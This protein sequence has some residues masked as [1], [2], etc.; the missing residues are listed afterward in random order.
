MRRLDLTFDPQAKSNAVEKI[1]NPSLRF[2]AIEEK[3]DGTPQKV[4]FQ[5]E[6]PISASLDS[7]NRS[8]TA[9]NLTFT[10]PRTAVEGADHVGLAV[11]GERLMWPIDTDLKD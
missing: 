9:E 6:V 4:L 11:V 5:S 10:V 1:N 3:G 7:S 8:A 2:V